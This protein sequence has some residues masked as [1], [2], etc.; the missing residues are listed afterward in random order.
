MVN[1]AK[2]TFTRV[3]T[4]TYVTCTGIRNDNKSIDVLIG[5]VAVGV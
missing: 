2:C 3:H 4:C 1:V 5:I